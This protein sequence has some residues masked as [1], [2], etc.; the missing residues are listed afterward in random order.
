MGGAQAL[1]FRGLPGGLC[2]GQLLGDLALDDGSLLRLVVL[3]LLFD[4]RKAALGLRLP[5]DVGVV[6]PLLLRGS[7]GRLGIVAVALLGGFPGG[8][9][10]LEAQILRRLPSGFGDFELFCRCGSARRC[11]LQAPPV[12]GGRQFCAQIVEPLLLAGFPGGL[13]GLQALLFAGLPI[14]LGG[15]KALLCARGPFLLR[16][17]QTLLLDGPLRLGVLR[18]RCLQFDELGLG[19]M[20]LL[21]ILDMLQFQLREFLLVLFAELFLRGLQALRFFRAPDSLHDR[22]FCLHPFLDQLIDIGAR[23]AA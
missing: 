12:L 1:G 23:C 21:Q 16:G 20:Q 13:G 18:R 7:P 6:E 2:S 22:E 15:F 19:G 11:A 17:G 14:F 4:Q 10:L 3:H 9:R 8:L 5:G